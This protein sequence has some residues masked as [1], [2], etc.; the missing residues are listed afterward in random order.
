MFCDLYDVERLCSRIPGGLKQ[1]VL[2]DPDDL[3]SQPVWY[4]Q[5]NFDA[6]EFKTGKDAYRFDCDRQQSRLTDKISANSIAGDV[7]EY[8]LA[9]TVRGIR[10]D[11]DLL[12]KRLLNRRIHVVAT[13][14]DGYQRFLPY[15]RLVGES[16]SGESPASR[17]QYSFTGVAR[18]AGIAPGVDATLT[19]PSGGGGGDED[20]API[21]I[22]TSASSYTYEVPAGKLLDAIV[23]LGDMDQTIDIGTS[24]GGTEI[25]EDYATAA[26]LP[27]TLSSALLYAP[28]ATNIYFSNLAGNNTIKVYLW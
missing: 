27:A 28:T 16:D 8:T 10:L 1:V 23:I 11:V 25:V 17:N 15:M 22:T 18:L 4:D 21:T 9:A 6:L 13:Y 19:P 5:P 14:G 12:R 3:V 7:V 2:I 26:N 20:M 24:M